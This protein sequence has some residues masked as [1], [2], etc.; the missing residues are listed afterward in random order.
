VAGFSLRFEDN[1][2]WKLE[3]KITRPGPMASNHKRG[4]GSSW[5]VAPTG[6]E[7]WGEGKNI[8]DEL[9]FA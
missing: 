7:G 5:T 9:I 2:H 4:Q 8:K 1:G 3:I 6:G